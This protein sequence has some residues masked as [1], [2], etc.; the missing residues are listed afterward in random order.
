MKGKIC[1]VTGATDGHGKAVAMA[2]RPLPASALTRARA[3]AEASLARLPVEAVAARPR[4][5]QEPPRPA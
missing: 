3:A 4:I 1:L 2:P 5:P